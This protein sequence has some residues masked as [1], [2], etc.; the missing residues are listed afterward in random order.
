MYVDSGL[1]VVD[2]IGR[3]L[4]PRQFGETFKRLSGQA[5]VPVT[6]LHTARHGF[7]SYL[8]DQGVP[9][10]IV[11]KVMGHASVDVTARVYAHAL[12]T[13]A[14]ERVRSAMVAA[15]L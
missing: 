5:G 6:T 10:P 14:D 9:L 4:H 7:G 13:G 8:L 11:S 1:V 3:P 2:E 12:S 15:G